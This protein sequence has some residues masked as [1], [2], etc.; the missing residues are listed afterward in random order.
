MNFDLLIRVVRDLSRL[1][2][3]IHMLAL[4][5]K[6]LLWAIVLENPRPILSNSGNSDHISKL[7]LNVPFIVRYEIP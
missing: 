4:F 6:E 3:E 2:C 5:L 1:F 7:T